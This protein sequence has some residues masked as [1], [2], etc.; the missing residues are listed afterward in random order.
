MALLIFAIDIRCSFWT[1]K[2]NESKGRSQHSSLPVIIG[3]SRGGIEGM[4]LLQVCQQH[5]AWL[6]LCCRAL[7]AAHM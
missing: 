6:A 1:N 3:A 7:C 4:P 2:L 5:L